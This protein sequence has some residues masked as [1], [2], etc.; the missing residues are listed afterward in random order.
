[1]FQLADLKPEQV[2]EIDWLKHRTAALL[3]LPVGF[4]KTII[5]LTAIKEI[6]DVYGPWTTLVISTKNIIRHTWPS[7]LENFEHI[8]HLT[9]TD[10]TDRRKASLQ[11]ETN[12]YGINFESLT[13]FLDQVDS[14]LFPSL[15]DIMVIDESSKMKAHSAERVKRLAGLRYI[16]R[17]KGVKNYRK[18]PGYIHRFKRRFLLSALPNP[19]GYEGL[20][21]QSCLLD[22]RRR[23]GENPT[24]FRNQ[25]CMRKRSGFGWTVV[26]AHEQ[27]IEKKLEYVMRVPAK[28]DYLD[29]PD[30]IHFAIEVPWSKDARAQ[31]KKMEDELAL[32]LESGVPDCPLDEIEIIA[33]NAGVLL[34]KLR[35][36]CSGFLYDRE[37]NAHPTASPSAKLEALDALLERCGDSPLLVFTQFRAEMASIGERYRGAQIGMPDT[38]EH[39]NNRE[40]PMLVLHPRSAAHGL[41]FQYGT[42]ICLYYS[43]P[44]SFD[45]WWQ[46][47]GRLQR[48]GQE[49]QVS[50]PRFERPNSVEQDVW[51]TIQG[52]GGKVSD[53]LS[54]ML[55]RRKERQ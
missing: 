4:G 34:S 6:M 7:E 51:K 27:T 29:L 52:K 16:T 25:Y 41:N 17:A 31:Y 46:S 48:R 11:M 15:P 24:S 35:Q 32:L 20:W 45:D 13:W 36:I 18:Y 14:G 22:T 26:P 3:T 21:S 55:Q 19:E 47:W 10:L 50:A 53:F 38:L 37:R 9:Y 40:I 28:Q 33:P 2:E 12:I 54:N 30:P 39:W 42:N 8:S 23:L 44:Y 43:L 49:W 1:M 5:A